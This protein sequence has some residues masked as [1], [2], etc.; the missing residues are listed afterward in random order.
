[1]VC[2]VGLLAVPGVRSAQS[3]RE[4]THEEE[5]CKPRKRT[6][7]PG[8]DSFCLHLPGR[9]ACHVFVGRSPTFMLLL[10][11]LWT[12]ITSCFLLSI[13]PSYLARCR[14]RVCT[15]GMGGWG[16]SRLLGCVI[17][18]NTCARTVPT[19]PTPSGVASQRTHCEQ[20]L[21]ERGQSRGPGTQW[22]PTVGTLLG[23]LGPASSLA[24]VLSCLNESPHD[25]GDHAD[26]SVAPG[27]LK[28]QRSAEQQGP[29]SLVSFFLV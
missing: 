5:L 27:R 20:L 6:Q 18:R 16:T 7:Q 17:S 8:A 9:T 12:A 10:L 26:S 2:T 29:R 13:D 23:P 15:H 19:P 4:L 1:M 21:R 14:H 22:T 3:C 24:I 28:S 11:S 25:W